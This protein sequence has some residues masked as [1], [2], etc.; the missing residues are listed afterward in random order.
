MKTQ[1]GLGK[2]LRHKGK[3]EHD[4]RK[5][6]SLLEETDE[7]T[8]SYN[9]MRQGL[10]MEGRTKC[11]GSTKGRTLNFVEVLEWGEDCGQ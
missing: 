8:H 6:G 11:F 9:T 4:F 10:Q 5:A 1:S 3:G 7:Q 2:H